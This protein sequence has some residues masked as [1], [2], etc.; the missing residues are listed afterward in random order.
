MEAWL[1]EGPAL[2]AEDKLKA[3]LKG[4]RAGDGAS[5]LT[6]WGTH[7]SDL[8][9]VYLGR[10]LGN[11]PLRAADCSTGEQRALLLS[12][13][14]AEARLARHRRGQAPILLLD[15]AVS[16]LDGQR[17]EA[18]VAELLALGLQA[19]LTG[20]DRDL[21]RPLAGSAQ[22]FAVEDGRVHDL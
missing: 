19:W 4:A 22:F 17:R 6:E 10:S 15:E 8:E 9:V 7:R 1:A 14:L 2:A 20:T 18:L 3:Q 13:A 16:H 5:G 11:A 12:I 21:F